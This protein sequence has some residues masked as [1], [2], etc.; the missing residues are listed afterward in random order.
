MRERARGLAALVV[1]RRRG[2]ERELSAAAD[3]GVVETLVADAGAIRSELEALDPESG[4]LASRGIEIEAAE[5]ELA[6]ER[7]AFA[8]DEDGDDPVAEAGAV[9]RELAARRDGLARIEAELERFDARVRVVEARHGQLAFELTSVSEQLRSVETSVPGATAASEAAVSARALAEDALAQAEARWRESESDASRWQAR[10][11]ALAQALDAASDAEAAVVLEGMLGVA[12]SLVNHLVIEPGAERAVA[13]A[14]G[15][16]MG[17]VIVSGRDEARGAVERL[18]SGDA[19]AWL[20]V[21]DAADTAVTTGATLAPAGARPLA[22]CVRASLPGL[23]ATLARTLAGVVLAD[24]DWRTAMD[25]AVAYP[26]LTVMTGTGDRFG[27][28]RPWRFG[29]EQS[30]GVT[31]AAFDEAVEAAERA[32]EARDAARSSVDA[33]RVAV[34]DARAVELRTAESARKA[35]SEFDRA[36]AEADRIASEREERNHELEVAGGTRVGLVEA[37]AAEHTRL[38]AL[39]ARLPELESAE[40]DARR[41]AEVRAVELADLERRTEAIA[42]LRREHSARVAALDERR[43]MLT[44]RGAEVEDRL[45]R[46]PEAKAAAE[47]YRAE[48]I[49]KRGAYER[50]G[51]ALGELTGRVD[52]VLAWLR[53]ER[54]IQTERASAAGGRLEELRTRRREDEQQLAEVRERMQRREVEEAENRMRLEATVERIRSEHDCEPGVAITTDAPEVPEGTT[55]AGRARDLDRDLRI[56]GPINPLALE[57][58]EALQERHDFL[59]QQLDDVKNSRRELQ[60]VI[61]AVDHEIVTVFDTAF[62]D[63]QENFAALFTTLFPGGSGRIYLTDPDDLLNTGIEMEA[64]PSGKNTKRL[65]LLSGG[66]R[67]LTAMAFLFAVFRSRPSPFYLLDEVEAALDDVN[68]HRFLDLL[69]EFRDEAQLL[70]VSHQKRTMEAGDCLYGVTMA[71]GG[72]TKVVSQR[73]RGEIVL[74]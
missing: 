6:A 50:V 27:G 10:A 74:T 39:E 55:L 43:S 71:P 37:L 70:V 46:D 4:G 29:A 25:L 59:V 23:Q 18:A 66:E 67:S 26:D 8:A 56:M 36:R 40:D 42:A 69:H 63:V 30:A 54:R 32:V 68:L 24:G 47:R 60:R 34:S 21:L 3:E 72:S 15:D 5:R 33:A 17:S 22:S 9:R 65:S 64:R 2:L 45:A 31:R 48:L 38:R 7:A 11:D 41:R 58:F 14:L 44:R 28:G 19:A 20:L 13:A 52:G 62:A 53:R 73:M 51:S 61:K 57:E 49:A 1:E 16:A 35:R 12:G